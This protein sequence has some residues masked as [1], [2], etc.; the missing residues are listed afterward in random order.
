MRGIGAPIDLAPFKDNKT[1]AGDTERCTSL[2]V[3]RSL[4]IDATVESAILAFLVDSI[5]K[6]SAL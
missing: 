2:T 6:S 3:Y 5:A 4:L 1:L